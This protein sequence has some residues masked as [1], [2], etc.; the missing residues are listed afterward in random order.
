MSPKQ[1][2]LL[3]L[4]L[5]YYIVRK[6]VCLKSFTNLIYLNGSVENFTIVLVASGSPFSYIRQE[7]HS[8]E[9]DERLSES[10]AIHG[11]SPLSL[12]MY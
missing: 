5:S 7:R 8:R 1:L 3:L 12:L 11:T 9:R 4:D 2:F 6:I 10:L